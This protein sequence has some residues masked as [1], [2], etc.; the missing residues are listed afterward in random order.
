MTNE[1][2]DTNELS[3]DESGAIE[4]AGQL[5][6][7]SG[8]FGE[9]DGPASFEDDTPNS[10][11]NSGAVII[12]IV[13]LTASASVIGMRAVSK[14][15]GAEIAKG[16]TEVESQIE[17]FLDTLTTS[18]QNTSATKVSE[19]SVM[20]VL[21][22]PYSEHQIPLEDVKKNPFITNPDDVSTDPDENN[23]KNSQTAWEQQRTDMIAQYQA[24]ADRI[25]VSSIMGG[26]SPLANIN[27]KYVRIGDT[28]SVEPDSMLFTIK[29]ISG[30]IV[31]LYAEVKEFDF[32]STYTISMKR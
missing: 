3:H 18:E 14:S 6:L 4:Q 12:A 31:T 19:A 2:I 28:L 10:R 8:G 5:P 26:S 9:A 15:A 29:S 21:S 17:S 24:A 13:I 23:S 32:K 20:K 27:G 30:G 16:N 7:G 22:T 11:I 1:S 25:V